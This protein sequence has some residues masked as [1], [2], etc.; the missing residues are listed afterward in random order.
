MVVWLFALLDVM[1]SGMDCGNRA[2]SLDDVDTMVS[3]EARLPPS[4]P[5]HPLSIICILGVF[6]HCVVG[7]VLASVTHSHEAV[8]YP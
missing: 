1:G 6:V 8:H 3:M 7:H 5:A 2:G 4:A